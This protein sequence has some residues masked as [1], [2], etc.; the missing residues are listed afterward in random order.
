MSESET[1]S[2]RHVREVYEAAAEKQA[3]S[4]RARAEDGE[5]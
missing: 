4:L 5:R 1:M 3:E 2:L